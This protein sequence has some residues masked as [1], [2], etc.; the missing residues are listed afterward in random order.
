LSAAPLL[1]CVE[2]EPPAPA[3]H[4]V[5]WMHGLG[6]D[7]HD[8][9]PLVPMLGADRLDVRFVFPHAPVQPITIDGGTPMRAWYD[10]VDLDLVGRADA[11]GVRD[12]AARIAALLRRENQRGIAD[13]RIVLAGFSQGGAMALHVGLRQA[14]PLAGIVALSCYLVC[15][16]TLAREVTPASREVPILLAHGRSDPL[17]PV[18]WGEAARDTLRG[19]GY[20]PQWRTYAIP[21]AVCAEE[22]LEIGQWLRE[23]FRDPENR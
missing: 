13:E 20:R 2:I 12:S 11:A 9:E 7:G 18:E 21:H 19:L 5:I 16:D 22:I 17:V 6:A 4:T 8:F 3:R 15:A 1:P 23:R 14:R 10:V